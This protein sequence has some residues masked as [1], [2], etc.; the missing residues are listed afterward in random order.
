MMPLHEKIE[1]LQEKQLSIE[2]TDEEVSK[3]NGGCKEI[4][5]CRYDVTLEAYLR[6]ADGGNC[7]NC[8]HYYKAGKIDRGYGGYYDEQY[9]CR[10]LLFAIRVKP[11]KNV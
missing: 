6:W 9:C 2:L 3:A 10:D 11:C 1:K 5:I 7:N 4:T 8:H